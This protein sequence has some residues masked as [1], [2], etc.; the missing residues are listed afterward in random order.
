MPARD[1]FHDAVRKALE[2]DGWSISHDPFRLG[3]GR[4]AMYV[5][6][7][8]EAVVAAEKGGQ[9]IAVE[10]KTLGGPSEVHDLQL[11]LGQYLLYRA[12]LRRREPDRTLY[13]AV[14]D[15]AFEELLDSDLGRLVR[16]EYGVL[17]LVFDPHTEVVLRWIGS[18]STES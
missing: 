14:S 13:L 17:A 4:H 10:V 8:A 6:L 7:A 15:T 12:V 5:D 16:E 11:A 9:R 1:D 18:T 3:W 2:K